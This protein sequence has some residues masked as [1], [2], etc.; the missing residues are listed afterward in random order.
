MLKANDTFTTHEQFPEG[1][2]CSVCSVCESAAFLLA[3]RQSRLYALA[4]REWPAAYSSYKGNVR[5]WIA[6]ARAARLAER[7]AGAR[8]P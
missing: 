8:L 3:A 7:L 4:S 2:T 1:R 6:A 5:L